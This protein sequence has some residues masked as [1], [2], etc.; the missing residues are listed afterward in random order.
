M[1]SDA[2]A[3]QKHAQQKDTED[4]REVDVRWGMSIANYLGRAHAKLCEHVGGVNALRIAGLEPTEQRNDCD[5]FQ[6]DS[7]DGGDFFDQVSRHR[8][9]NVKMMGPQH[10][11]AKPLPAVAGRCRLAC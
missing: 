5:D 8:A 3:M 9:P 4:D 10:Y 2:I 1:A 6:R 11:A 7:E